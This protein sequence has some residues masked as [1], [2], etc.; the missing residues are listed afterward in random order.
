M[1]YPSSFNT[2]D[3]VKNIRESM[4]ISIAELARRANISKNYLS[5]IERG[6]NQNLSN[7]IAIG[8]AKALCEADAVKSRDI[9]LKEYDSPLA[10]LII[11]ELTRDEKAKVYISNIPEL[12]QLVEN[13]EYIVDGIKIIADMAEKNKVYA[14]LKNDLKEFKSVVMLHL[15]EGVLRGKQLDEV[16]YSN[17]FLWLLSSTNVKDKFNNLMRTSIDSVD[18]KTLILLCDEIITWLRDA[19][20]LHGGS[21]S[22]ELSFSLKAK[23]DDTETF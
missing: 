16:D 10:Q 5:R 22:E 19:L 2:G 18:E 9:N 23:I 14:K 13:A 20:R 11:D 17:A 15:E 21:K 7:D 1:S 8:L 3:L 6:L 4:N 12:E